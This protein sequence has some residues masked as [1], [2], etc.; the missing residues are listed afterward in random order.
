VTDCVVDLLRA[1]GHSLVVANN[2]EVRT[3]DGRGVADLHALLNRDSEFCRGAEIADKVV[4]KGAAALM[5]AGGVGKVFAEVVS[6]P[7]L[8]LLKEAGVDVSFGY[9]VPNIIN[10]KGDDICPVE[11]LCSDCLT[12]AECLPL[13]DDFVEKSKTNYHHATDQC[14]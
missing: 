1:G 2:G 12:A 4:G 9:E 13:I 5:V 3:F 8:R 6:T 11:K 10:R 14:S 7:A